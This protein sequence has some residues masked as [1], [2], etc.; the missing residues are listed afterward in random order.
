MADVVPAFDFFTTR[1]TDFAVEFQILQVD[2]VTPEDIAGWSVAA[3][4]VDAEDATSPTIVYSAVITDAG[5]GIVRVVA[6]GIDLASITP[7]TL[8][9]NLLTTDLTGSVK[10]RSRWRHFL[11]PTR[12]D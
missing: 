3:H 11:L 7:R 2:G 8:Y 5:N 1:N 4:G 10:E 12:T 6:L 9:A